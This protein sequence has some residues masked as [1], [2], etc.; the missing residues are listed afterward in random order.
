MVELGFDIFLLDFC[1]FCYKEIGVLV[2][3]YVDDLFILVFMMKI[4]ED[5]VIGLE[6][7]YGIKKLGELKRFLGFDIV[8]NCGKRQV[9]LFQVVYID[10]LFEKFGYKDMV[11]VVMLWLVKLE[12]FFM[13][14]KMIVEVKEYIWKIGVLNWLF[15]GIWFDIIFIVNCFCGGNFGFLLCYLE[16]MKYFFWYLVVIRKLCI[17]LGGFEFLVED[18][19]FVGFVDVLYVDV[20][21]WR[22]FI[23]GYVVFVVGGLVLWKSKKQIFVVLSMMEVEFVNLMFI[24]YLLQWVLKILEDCG[25]LQLRLYMLYIDSKNVEIIVLNFQNI[26][27]IWC[28]DIWYKWV[29]E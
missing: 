16:L 10:V 3:L 1:L 14:E 24:G 25:V 19:K 8:R 5:I 12:F 20:L 23:G 4:I 2:V 7:K 18:M 27:R 17:V 15:I 26:V 11:G 28:I 9:Y 21:F 13:W 6:S 22:Y 29:G